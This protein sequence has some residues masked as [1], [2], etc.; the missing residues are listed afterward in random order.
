[1][2]V[3]YGR[4][5]SNPQKLDLFTST[6]NA[7][8][9]L[10]GRVNHVFGLVGPCLT[11]DTSC[12]S[13]LV[14]THLAVNSLRNREC[15]AAIAGGVNLQLEPF[16]MILQAR[17][18]MLSPEGKCKTFDQKAN[19]FARGE[20]CGVVLLKR[21]SDAMKDG[22][23]IHAVIRGTAINHDGPSGGLTVPNGPMQQDVIRRALENGRVD[24]LQV[25]Y[26]EAHGTGTELGD[27]IEI[28]ALGRSYCHNRDGRHPLTVGS[29]KTNIGHCES[30]AGIAGL[31]KTIVGL[32]HQTIPAQIHFETPNPHIPW[33]RYPIEIARTEQAWSPIDGRRIAGVSSFGFSGTN[34]H[35]VMEEAPSVVPQ[36]SCDRPW[37]LLVLSAKNQGALDHIQKRYGEFLDRTDADAGSVCHAGAVGRSHL[38][39]RAAVVGT[40]TGDL[41]QRL[42]RHHLVRGK[43]SPQPGPVA[44]LFAGED[45][46]CPGMGKALYETNEFFRGH[47]DRCNDI[48]RQ[49]SARSLFDLLWDESE[50][51]VEGK[52]EQ[53]VAMFALEYSLYRW[54]EHLGLK[55]QYVLGQ[56]VGE[57][58][59]ACV[60]GVF[61]LEQG[62]SLAWQWVGVSTDEDAAE[63]FRALLDSVN[64]SSPHLG[65][66]T[67]DSGG[68]EPECW[69]QPQFWLK[70]A[71][72]STQQTP[73][74]ETL[75]AEGVTILLEV[76]P[77]PVFC[78]DQN[79]ESDFHNDS[80][81][82]LASLSR[83][84]N[85]WKSLLDSIAVLYVS[86]Q[87]IQW[88][89]LD[90]DYRFDPVTLPNYAFQRKSYWLDHAKVKSEFTV[91]EAAEP[92]ATAGSAHPL[93]GTRQ[94][95]PGGLSSYR[96]TL[97][98]DRQEYIAQHRTQEYPVMPAA[99]YLAMT[100]ESVRR[101]NDSA[102]LT[103]E[104]FNV[105][106]PLVFN[107]GQPVQL[108]TQVKEGQQ[109]GQVQIF[110]DI[111]DS[112]PDDKNPW[113]E[114]AAA[115][116]FGD[117]DADLAA[118]DQ[119]DDYEHLTAE[120]RSAHYHYQRAREKG[121]HYGDRY[122]LI[123]NIRRGQ[124]MALATLNN[125]QKSPFQILYLLDNVFQTIDAALP[126][127]YQNRA[128][129]PSAVFG[130]VCPESIEHTTRIGVAIQG[131]PSGK[132]I[133][134]SVSFFSDTHEVTGRIERVDMVCVQHEAR[135][136]T[137]TGLFGDWFY[138]ILWRPVPLPELEAAPTSWLVIDPRHLMTSSGL[139]E[140]FAGCVHCVVD[141]N[142]AED[143]VRARMEI[144]SLLGTHQVNGVLFL[145]R[146]STED[147]RVDVANL[148][149]VLQNLLAPMAAKMARKQSSLPVV[150]G[151]ELSDES[152]DPVASLLSKS[153]VGLSN[154][155]NAEWGDGLHKLVLLDTS[156]EE[157]LSTLR[158]E[159]V[160]EPQENAVRY[161]K[162]QRL[163]ARIESRSNQVDDWLAQ[164]AALR[165]AN[166][167]QVSLREKG[168]LD[169]FLFQPLTRRAPEPDEIEI[170]VTA[171][172]V[173]F[174]DLLD[175]M[176]LLPIERPGGLGGEC[177]GV[178]VR[179]G[180]NVQRFSSGDRVFA[181][182]TGS[183]SRYVTVDPAMVGRLPDSLTL[184]EGATL[185][186]AYL[187]A[188]QALV[189]LVAIKPGQRVLV[190]SAAGG[191]GQAMVALAQHL[192]AEVFGTCS[193]AK[194]SFLRDRGVRVYDSRSLAFAEKLLADTG[195]EG[196]DVVINCLTG[197]FIPKSFSVLKDGGT[198][199]EIGKRE[200][201]SDEQAQAVW[202]SL[203]R[204]G[205]VS[206]QRLDLISESIQH[207]ER[208]AQWIETL[209]SLF[210]ERVLPALPLTAFSMQDIEKAFRYMQNARHI[211]KIVLEHEGEGVRNGAAVP[212]AHYLITGGLGDLGFLIATDLVERGVRQLVLTGRSRLQHAQQ[213]KID[214][215]KAMGAE[216]T[217]WRCDVADRDELKACMESL[218]ATTPGF[219]GV[220]HCAG[221]I[222]DNLSIN[223][224]NAD[225]VD[226]LK[227]KVQGAWNLHE[228]TRE[229]P[230][231]EFIL[232]ASAATLVGTPGQ[233]HYAFANRF[234]DE[235]AVYRHSQDLPALSIAWSLWASSSMAD[236]A[237]AAST[238]QGLM[239]IRSEEGLALLGY[240]KNYSQ[241]TIGVMPMDWAALRQNSPQADQLLAQK[242][243]YSGLHLEALPQVKA[244]NA[245]LSE[246]RDYPVAMQKSLVREALQKIVSKIFDYPS[247]QDVDPDKG[248]TD[249]GVD[250]LTAMEIKGASEKL[251]GLKIPN[252]ALFD[253]PTLNALVEFVF[254]QAPF[255]PV[256]DEKR[257]ATEKVS[258]ARENESP[259]HSGSDP[260]VSDE[261]PESKASIDDNGADKNLS[262]EQE[263]AA[264]DQL[265]DEL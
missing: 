156:V 17:A 151:M 59:A 72:Q 187:T 18:N 119:L 22:D 136:T 84:Q 24:P 65:L 153:L 69:T 173:N 162:G 70:R 247:W 46:H 26:V 255:K 96:Q 50:Q 239:P 36:S 214:R 244:T 21:L 213:E 39:Y 262:I 260:A 110:A 209:E 160:V 223:L 152:A 225:I 251:L 188:Y 170:E 211:G 257:I 58:V 197:E 64:F 44:V 159:C 77:K 157:S 20:G 108:I 33:D 189:H 10:S 78:S 76:G 234:L 103:I 145:D 235:L 5:L 38:G 226:V 203:G 92:Q 126:D 143:L 199:V 139:N 3:D 190:H 250:S 19:G 245:F 89:A 31:I 32:E 11:L 204:E 101:V 216:V 205:E 61:S 88:H 137:L 241:P 249:L 113:T 106:R 140:T 178:V 169:N 208:V 91:A 252:T 192:G 166:G 218:P 125:S 68:I 196:V 165:D 132:T 240:L 219:T 177:A 129:V 66:V 55:P 118:G 71:G 48:I 246:L 98:A 15:D 120:I 122:R 167:Y 154:V 47:L 85:D 181:M 73:G 182:A 184:Q 263:L 53:A 229:M 185:P 175:V 2:S 265:L 114:M 51:W 133:S 83:D 23:R 8:S 146:I 116:V 37:H 117:S 30:A 264:M 155:V 62:I 105:W 236:S 207:P 212:D 254:Q 94:F 104:S 42:N 161:L 40:S 90:E 222:R 231:R 123:S 45:A 191:T 82:W 147:S 242:A 100:L 194:Q 25:S 144:E 258:P 256:A 107:S 168:T 227:P 195:N 228:L 80:V 171:S 142:S 1:M 63:A 261:S 130:L 56:G 95:L 206:Y 87:P 13:S 54:W 135:A 253:Y 230:V 210:A 238:A 183:F 215:L 41:A 201:L 172:G 67:S 141:M 248:F 179:T 224:T 124:G 198:F 259:H 102:L 237:H 186:V 233:S 14:A 75:L 163:A 217:Y 60:A 174:I 121:L 99:A 158:D 150:W 7:S 28:E 176:G 29:V 49:Y 57:F 93:L 128:Y 16:M 43:S 52:R 180:S 243:F 202:G 79:S 6:G 149:L 138:D 164:D 131:D 35:V 200:L 9:V 12:S 27:P 4:L 134:A 97:S 115:S 148:S 232:F 111:A 34:A 109:R 220:I 74:I 221:I 86:G 193:Q 127:D 81:N 112:Y